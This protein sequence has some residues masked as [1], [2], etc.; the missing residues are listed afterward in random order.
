MSGLNHV[1]SICMGSSLGAN[2]ICL[3]CNMG[4]MNCLNIG[5]NSQCFSYQ[6]SKSRLSQLAQLHDLKLW[7]QAWSTW[8]LSRL[9]EVQTEINL[10]AQPCPMKCHMLITWISKRTQKLGMIIGEEFIICL[11]LYVL[12]LNHQKKHQIFQ[13]MLLNHLKEEIIDIPKEVQTMQKFC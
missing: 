1:L 3:G 6:S 8:G 5:D 2:T 9:H 12:C 10:W 11:L 7:D 4:G 13:K